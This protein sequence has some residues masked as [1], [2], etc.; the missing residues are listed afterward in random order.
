MLRIDNH[1]RTQAAEKTETIRRTTMTAGS[2]EL[3]YEK[4]RTNQIRNVRFNGFR[5]NNRLN[6]YGRSGMDA[7]TVV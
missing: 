6:T 2:R 1:E 7:K 5:K 3:N 4:S